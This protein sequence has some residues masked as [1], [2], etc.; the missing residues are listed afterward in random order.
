TWI[1]SW[2]LL[3]LFLVLIAALSVARL[4]G[5]SWGLA[6]LLALGLTWIEPGAP[7]WS[8][9]ALLL[10]EAL[11]RALPA[12]RLLAL[13]RIARGLAVVVLAIVAVPFMVQQ[14]REAIYPALEQ[15]FGPAQVYG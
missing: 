14:A 1:S 5:R 10:F 3:D 6:A 4:H 15:P 9:L 12:G 2:T 11:A 7:R 13:V 8:W